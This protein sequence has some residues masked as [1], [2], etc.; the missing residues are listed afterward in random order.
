MFFLANNYCTLTT[1]I[2]GPYISKC[3]RLLFSS[4]VLEWDAKWNAYT[5][6]YIHFVVHFDPLYPTSAE[7]S[8]R[9]LV[10]NIWGLHLLLIICQ[11][12]IG[13]FTCHADRYGSHTG[14]RL[15]IPSDGLSQPKFQIYLYKSK[16]DCFYSD[17]LHSVTNN[18][19][20]FR[21]VY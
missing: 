16:L 20:I 1:G 14:S 5:L 15:K 4:L 10:K 6:F 8:G 7:V 19:N 12:F 13:S 11:H 3:S 17:V 18:K 9:V 21:I 2:P